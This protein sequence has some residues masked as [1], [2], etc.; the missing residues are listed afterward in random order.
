MER[1]NILGVNVS[2]TTYEELKESVNKDIINHHKSFIVAINHW[3]RL[4][5]YVM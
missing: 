5:G 3:Y 2:V 4:Y 1:E